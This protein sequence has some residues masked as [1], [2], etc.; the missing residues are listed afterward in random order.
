MKLYRIRHKETGKY[1]ADCHLISPVAPRFNDS[2]I[3]WKRIDTIKKHLKSLC[4]MYIWRHPDGTIRGHGPG[5]DTPTWNCRL[6]MK[7]KNYE[8]LS[9]YEV[10]ISNVNVKNTELVSA[11]KLVKREIENGR[12]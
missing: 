6:E 2:G 11:K 8:L 9:L 10:E 3:F 12:F 4:C 5:M 1:L 7:S